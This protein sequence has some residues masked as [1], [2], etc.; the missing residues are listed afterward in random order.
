[1]NL[2][3]KI[4]IRKLQS[5][6]LTQ[7]LVTQSIMDLLIEKNVFTKEEIKEKIDFNIELWEELVKENKKL[8]EMTNEVLERLPEEEVK[9]EEFSGL[10]YGP[11]G[12]C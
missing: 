7:S 4:E 2:I 10:Y 5:K 1:M 11:V 8:L 9:D 6:L 3:S 12:E